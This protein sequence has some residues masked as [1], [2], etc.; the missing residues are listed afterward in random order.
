[1]SECR[2]CDGYGIVGPQH[3]LFGE[4]GFTPCPDCEGAKKKVP[5][6]AVADDPWKPVTPYNGTSGWSGTDTSLERAV[7][8][9]IDGTTSERQARVMGML[10]RAGTRG[11]TWKELGEAGGWHHGTASGALSTLHKAERIARLLE[12]RDRCRVY[13]ALE[14]VN[15]RETDSQ[16]RR[17]S[18]PNCGW[19]A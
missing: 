3:D 11:L 18:C 14:H 7:R 16:G 10:R 17:H 1:M 8:A 12:R 13:V 19:A 2:T 4:P 5:V 15:G 9:D 6:P